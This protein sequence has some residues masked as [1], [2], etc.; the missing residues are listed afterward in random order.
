MRRAEQGSMV[1]AGQGAY[2]LHCLPLSALRTFCH[3]PS[4]EADHLL[5]CTPLEE[6]KAAEVARL[7]EDERV[8]FAIR[9][10]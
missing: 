5:D 8:A 10:E 4:D 1:G 2:L 6:T 3:C 9:L 7:A